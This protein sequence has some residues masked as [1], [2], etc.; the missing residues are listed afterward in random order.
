MAQSAGFQA[1]SKMTDN[2][3]KVPIPYFESIRPDGTKKFKPKTW[4]EQIQQYTDRLKKVKVEP[5]LTGGK[6]NQTKTQR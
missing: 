6:D 5:M 1:D 4:L 2:N 3:E